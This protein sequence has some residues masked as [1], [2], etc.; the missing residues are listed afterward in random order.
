MVNSH[1]PGGAMRPI[2]GAQDGWR[3]FRGHIAEPRR[4][5]FS[6]SVGSNSGT[7]AKDRGDVTGI[8]RDR[9]GGTRMRQT[10]RSS[11]IS[12]RSKRPLPW[13]DLAEDQRAGRA[14]VALAQQRRH[15][16]LPL[17]AHP[18]FHG[19]PR[20]VIPRASKKVPPVLSRPRKRGCASDRLRPVDRHRGRNGAGSKRKTEI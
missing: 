12:D 5:A 2:A 9:F 8:R 20:R 16:F 15:N 19:P 4:D 18:M 6:T 1:Q 13:P 14:S 17:T 10:L 11:R 3:E 7:R